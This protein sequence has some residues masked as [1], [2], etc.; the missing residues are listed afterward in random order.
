VVLTALLISAVVLS[1]PLAEW[2]AEI[3][4]RDGG[5][6]IP[7]R[8]Y[9]DRERNEMVLPEDAEARPVLRRFFLRDEFRE[10]LSQAHALTVNWDGIEGRFHF[11]VMNMAL[12]DQWKDAEDA[13]LAHEFGHIWLDATGYKSLP[14]DAGAGSCLGIHASDAVQHILIRRE[15]ARRSISML[16]YWL[17]NLEQSLHDLETAPPRNLSPCQTLTQ[18][19]QWIDAHLGLT[20]ETWD[21]LPR[22]LE[23]MNENYPDLAP[24]E[25]EIADHLRAE[26]LTDPDSYRQALKFSL[27]KF[28]AVFKGPAGS[29]VL[30]NKIPA[31]PPH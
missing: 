20:P 23:L 8:I 27:D 17:P 18:L 6:I 28:T 12:A 11:I 7:V 31:P 22:F 3:E 2:K 1:Q 30:E 24:C 25:H 14:Y 4:K 10:Q 26:D 29:D 13:M 21:H 15:V 19:G 16:P 5:K 9:T